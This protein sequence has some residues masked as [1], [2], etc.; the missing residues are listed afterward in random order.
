MGTTQFWYIE[1]TLP[2]VV[3]ETQT[4][5][6]E[7]GYWSRMLCINDVDKVIWTMLFNTPVV[8]R[9]TGQHYVYISHVDNNCN[10]GNSIN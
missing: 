2:Q 5:V 9:K 4:T 6:F 3:S 8:A 10:P 1:L 7:I